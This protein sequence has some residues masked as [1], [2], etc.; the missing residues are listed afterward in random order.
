MKYPKCSRLPQTTYTFRGYL[1]DYLSG[2]T[3][4]WL[5]ATPLANPGM[6]EIFRDRDR[7]RPTRL[8]ACIR[9]PDTG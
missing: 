3:E 1:A 4:Q 9:T 7:Q 6:L 2:V 8:L 5:K